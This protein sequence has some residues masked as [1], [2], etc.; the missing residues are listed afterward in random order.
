MSFAKYYIDSQYLTHSL[1]H[2]TRLFSL[3]AFPHFAIFPFSIQ[4]NP[5]Q[6][7]VRIIRCCICVYISSDSIL[8]AQYFF[9]IATFYG[10]L[11]P[12]ISIYTLLLYGTHNV[13]S[14]TAH[15]RLKKAYLPYLCLFL[16]FNLST[17][18]FIW[19][20]FLSLSIYCAYNAHLFSYGF[21]TFELLLKPIP[22][23]LFMFTLCQKVRIKTIK[24]FHSKNRIFFFFCT[25]CIIEYN[26]TSCE[27]T[28][29]GH[30]NLKCTVSC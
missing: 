22:P 16:F 2:S 24:R 19:N 9:F 25:C 11:F 7:S 8:Y 6:S 28:L 26:Y 1:T 30:N 4:F 20:W 29:S 23:I 17:S 13:S 15:M 10:L 14:S 18:I 21:G 5:I 27:P 12:F 3:S